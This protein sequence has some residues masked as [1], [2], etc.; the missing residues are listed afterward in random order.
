MN[1]DDFIVVYMT[2]GDAGE[3]ERISAALLDA[4][5]VACAN[6]MAPHTAHYN[7]K[8]K[9]ERG[10][11]VAV[12]MKTR[13]ALLEQARAAAQRLHSYECPCIVAWPLAAGHV[14][15]LDWIAAETS[16]ST[17]A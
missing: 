4:K 16:E 15:F 2:C 12:I 13:S 8:G 6:I 9:R 17:A 3:A 11:E 10:T 14:P 1:G 5:L 7:W